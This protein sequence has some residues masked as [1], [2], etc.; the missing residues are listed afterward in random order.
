VTSAYGGG[1]FI[2]D[3]SAW[4][5]A[6]E[7][8]VGPDWTAAIRNDQVVLSPIVAL[9]LLQSARTGTEFAEIEEELALF[10]EVAL[11]H[12]IARAATDA[13]RELSGRGQL[14][15]RLPIQDALIAASAQDRGYG[16]L[17]YDYHYDRLATVL[18]FESR[19]IV[20]RGSLA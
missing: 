11:S 13:L 17:H 20:P 14:L 9:E 8:T 2:A 3:T 12:G 16:V 7:S 15:H 1:V 6:D 19:W 18:H 4:N 5:R 10:R